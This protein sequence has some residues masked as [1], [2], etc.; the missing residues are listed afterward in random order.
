MISLV[1]AVA[2]NGV[3]GRA[4]GL[5]WHISSDL[6]R[7]KDIT[8]GKPVIMGRK[9]WDSLPRKPLSGRRN[10]VITRQAGFAA[11][12]ADVVASAEAALAL[13]G[14]VPE[15]AIIGGG[16]IYRM[17]WPLADRLYL[18]GVDIE[19]EGDTSFPEVVEADW[20]ERSREVHQP[21]PR[22]SAGFILRILDKMKKN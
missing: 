18:T 15:I 5:P 7:F 13:C 3:I 6:K 9:T 19:I 20:I 2:R 10:I 16:E 4:G 12:G 21:G 8:M 22:D 1:V 14:P 11:P 17:F